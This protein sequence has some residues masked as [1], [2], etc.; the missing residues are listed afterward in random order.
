MLKVSNIGGLEYFIPENIH[1]PMTLCKIQFSFNLSFKRDRDIFWNCTFDPCESTTC[2]AWS[3]WPIMQIFALLR[4]NHYVYYAKFNIPQWTGKEH[5][6]LVFFKLNQPCENK[7]TLN[8]GFLIE[9][10]IWCPINKKFIFEPTIQKR[11]VFWGVKTVTN[12][13]LSIYILKFNLIVRLREHKQ[14]K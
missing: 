13:L 8:N 1:T 6:F 3:K 9:N 11:F 7:N 2:P 12:R 5:K 4:V 10:S 14:M